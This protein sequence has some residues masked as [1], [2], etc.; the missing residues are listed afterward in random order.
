M[1]NRSTFCAA[2]AEARP[3]L[4]LTLLV[5]RDGAKPERNLASIALLLP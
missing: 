3:S 4:E 2:V 1:A 5:P